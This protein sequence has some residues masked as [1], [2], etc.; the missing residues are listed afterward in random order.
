MKI[1]S[2]GNISF[3]PFYVRSLVL[4]KYVV[5]A[6][7]CKFASLIIVGYLSR[8]PV[9]FIVYSIRIYPILVQSSSFIGTFSP[10]QVFHSTPF[11]AVRSFS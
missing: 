5:S 11:G 2:N 4:L 9:N 8:A 10:S 7:H 1:Y 6:L 3:T